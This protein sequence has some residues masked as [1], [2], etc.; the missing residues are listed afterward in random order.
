VKRIL[1]LIVAAS[2]MTTAAFAEEI[3]SPLV[4]KNAKSMAMGG[5]FSSLPTAEFSFFGNPANFADKKASFTV[6]SVDAWAYIKPTQEN[7]DMLMETLPKI[8]S[9][10]DNLFSLIPSNGG[11]GGGFSLSALSFAGKGLGVGFQMTS[12]NYALGNDLPSS[13]LTIDTEAS[14]VIGLGIPLT[15]GGLRLSVG[16]DLR[17]FYRIRTTDFPLAELVQVMAGAVDLDGDGDI[18]DFDKDPLNAI[19]DINAGF[20][21]ALDVGATLELGSLAFG[22]SIRDIAPPFPVWNGTASDLVTSVDENG[23][24]P[25][26]TEE[27]TTK[28][29]FV[30]NVTVGLSWAP[31]LLPGILEPAVYFELQ[32]PISVAKNWDGAGSMLNLLHVG[33]EIKLLSMVSLRGGLNRGWLSV[34]AGFK[35]L[36]IDVN[37]AIFTEELGAVAG[38]RPRSGIAL[39]AAIRF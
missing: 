22:L 30:P 4:P 19:D 33:T 32:D 28:V 31:R 38:D 3:Y 2:L 12:D 20:G 5:A 11:I 7:V 8:E 23:S 13:M 37:G 25:E 6:T 34:G 36:F 9:D 21:L 1:I 35:L 18:D 24:L 17:P 14:A 27:N 15:L 29:T 26:Q 39:Q 10:Y 16:G